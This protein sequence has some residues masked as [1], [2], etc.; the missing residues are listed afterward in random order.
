MKELIHNSSFDTDLSM[1]P[2]FQKETT[3]TSITIDGQEYDSETL[4]DEAKSQL[5]SIQV[6]DKKIADLNTEVA[7]MQT[8]RNAYAKA[9]NEL[10]PKNMQ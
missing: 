8:A 1:T 7:I 3:M 6:V 2:I 9:L 4:S 10:L 5:I